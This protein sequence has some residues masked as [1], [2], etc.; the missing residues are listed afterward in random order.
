[1]KIS[2]LKMYFL[3]WVS[4]SVLYNAD[5][6]RVWVFFLVL[7][8]VIFCRLFFPLFCFCFQC[9]TCDRRRVWGSQS[10]ASLIYLMSFLSLVHNWIVWP[11]KMDNVETEMFKQALSSQGVS[12]G[13]HNAALAKVTETL[14]KLTD[15]VNRLSSGFEAVLA[16][17]SAMPRVVLSPPDSPALAVFSSPLLCRN[18]ESRTSLSPRAI[19]AI[20]E[21]ALSFFTSA[22]LCFSNSRPLT[23]L[24]AQESRENCFQFANW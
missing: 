23:P 4:Q 9:G 24:R 16:Q 17:R 15:S 3:Q 11:W 10:P 1:M 14:L 6:V 12:I 22:H 21:P 13:Q 2:L 19:P 7:F 18:P 8:V 20:W 5:I